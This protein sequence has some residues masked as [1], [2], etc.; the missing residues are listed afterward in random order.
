VAS[1]ERNVGSYN[2]YAVAFALGLIVS[3]AATPLVR[4]LALRL[5]AIDGIDSTDAPRRIHTIPTPRLGGLA[6]VL[7]FFVPA[8]GLLFWDNDIT[9]GLQGDVPLIFA[10]FGGGVVIVGLGMYDDIKGSNAWQKLAVQVSIGISM[11]ALGIRIDQVSIPFGEPFELGWLALPATIV[12]FVA[13]INAVN[14]IDGLDG[15][16]SG[17]AFVALAITFIIAADRHAILLAALLAAMAGGVLGFMPYNFNPARIFMG[18]TGSMFLGFALALTTLKANQKSSTAVTILVPIVVLAFPLTD[19]ALA[20]IRRV[21]R[22]DN[23]LSGDREH[24]HHRLLSRGLSQRSVAFVLYFFSGIAGVMALLMS[25][26]SSSQTTLLLVGLLILGGVLLYMLGYGSF[27]ARD[28]RNLGRIRRDKL[29][30]RLAAARALERLKAAKQVDD[31]WRA[32][33]PFGDLIDCSSV[34]LDVNLRSSASFT[35]SCDGLVSDENAKAESFEFRADVTHGNG[36]CGQLL[37]RWDDRDALDVRDEMTIRNIEE[38]VSEAVTRLRVLA[39][40][41]DCKAPNTSAATI[42]N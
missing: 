26:A 21:L 25:Y 5:R 20:I 24:I 27:R 23:P 35:W 9:R 14:L 10:L 16:A 42:A 12:W 2:T 4:R 41:Q 30:V 28:W 1:L 17:V 32:V 15:L 40:G 38:G 22:G 36:V 19:T 31:V 39:D 3:F 8:T 18:D 6:I 34:R 29:L 13:I 11:Y 33:R 7:G 37:F